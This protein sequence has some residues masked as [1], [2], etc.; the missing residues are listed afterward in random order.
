[1]KI[2]PA[3]QANLAS[4]DYNQMVS[5]GLKIWNKEL[6]VHKSVRVNLSHSALRI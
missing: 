1:M 6:C 5:C 3:V 2:L 4:V